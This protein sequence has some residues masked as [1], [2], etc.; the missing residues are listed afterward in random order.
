MVFNSDGIHAGDTV[1]LHFSIVLENGLV[2]ETTFDD[3]PIE[4]VVGDGTLNEGL[5]ATLYGMQEGE[6]QTVQLAPEQAF[7]LH[8]PENFQQ[9]ERSGFPSDMPLEPGTVIGFTTPNND[10]VPGTIRETSGDR[11]TIDF[12][13]PLA[14]H[15]LTFTVEI[16]SIEKASN[17]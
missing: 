17:H 1:T 15:T 6:S 10:E 11:V 3:D 2:A 7:G 14:G 13:H 16:I 5:E 12:N 4:Y 9:M 8:D